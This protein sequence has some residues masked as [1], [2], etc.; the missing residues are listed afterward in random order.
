[1]MMKENL[2]SHV[3]LMIGMQA[4]GHNDNYYN[5]IVTLICLGDYVC[6]VTV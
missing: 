2:Y 1:M 5:N 3:K 6:E 4:L